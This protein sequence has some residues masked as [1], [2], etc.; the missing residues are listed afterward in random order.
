MA[1]K[2]PPRAIIE[3]V[4]EFKRLTNKKYGANTIATATQTIGLSMRYIPTGSYAFDFGLGGGFPENRFSELRGNYS[5][6]KSTLS[7][8]GARQF[9]LKYPQG[10]AFLIDAE[11]VFDPRYMAQLKVEPKRF[12]VVNPSCGEEAVDVITEICRMP[13]PKFIIVD[14]I[15]A[16]VPMVETEGSINDSS[17]GVQARLIGRMVRVVT[18]AMKRSLY[19][20]EA[21]STTVVCLNQI[22]EKIGVMFGS[23][24]VTPGGRA[25]DFYYGVMVR[26]SAPQSEAI[27]QDIEVN[28]VARKITVA[29]LVKFT[30]LKN[31]CGGPQFEEGQFLF[32]KRAYD[33]HKPYTF[34][35][36]ESLYRFARF[37]DL[38]KIGTLKTF[39]MHTNPADRKLLK[40]QVLK[41]IVTEVYPE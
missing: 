29:Q 12:H 7:M 23:P 10:E 21:P 6:F 36:A 41:A 31:K 16:L 33:G 39:M 35:N 17:M 40:A 30:V 26:L 5:S 32:Y 9:Q 20:K 28:G 27:K 15:P 19:D 38:T 3:D 8:S 14:S 1:K 22:R 4:E 37:Y 2:R 25:K 18:T 11:R 13:M 34:N 24:E